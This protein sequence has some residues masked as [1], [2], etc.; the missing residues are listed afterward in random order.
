M[1]EVTE[2]LSSASPSHLRSPSPL[3]K[4]SPLKIIVPCLDTFLQD[5]T[6]GRLL[7][8]TFK[9]LDFLNFALEDDE[10]YLEDDNEMHPV[11]EKALAAAWAETEALCGAESLSGLPLTLD[12]FKARINRLRKED[13][14][15]ARIYRSMSED[16]RRVAQEM[17]Q[18]DNTGYTR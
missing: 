10:E 16:E 2:I 14:L 18:G 15:E 13:A 3:V 11:L 12:S 6:Y 17:E 8:I 4:E 1:T 7:S 9:C 5:D